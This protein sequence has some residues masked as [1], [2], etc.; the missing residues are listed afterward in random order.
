VTSHIFS[1][2]FLRN[3]KRQPP[4]RKNN[5]GFLIFRRH[6][7]GKLE[8]ASAPKRGVENGVGKVLHKIILSTA[9][10]RFKLKKM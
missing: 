6:A 10:R 2:V 8:S 4:R 3:R 1:C 7:A 5:D 9:A